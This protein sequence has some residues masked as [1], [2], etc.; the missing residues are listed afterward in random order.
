[1]NP[2]I[3]QFGPLALHWYG[4]F[5]VGGA[6]LATWLSARRAT[7]VGEDPDHVWNLLLWALG[8]GIIGARLYHVFSSPA[9]GGG[10]D[11]YRA[12]PL[13]ILMIWNGG[14]GIYGGLLGGILGIWIYTRRHGLSLLAYLDLIA[15]NVLLA[16][17][18][19]RLGNF[20]NQELYGPPTDLPWAF[21]INPI[22]PCQRPPNLPLNIQPCASPNLSAESL[23]WYAANGFHPTFFYEA[24]W[25]LLMFGLLTW[26]VYHFGSRLRRGD[27]TL[28]YFIAYPLGRFWVEFLR[29]DA[30]TLGSLATAQWIA[31]ISVVSAT[32]L[33]L[34]RRRRGEER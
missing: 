31:L 12:N 27:A 20:V 24:L 29:P 1:M 3:F 32:S 22:F 7:Q 19:G 10:W 25:N 5:I 33:L 23:A 13:A 14:L 8:F 30:W 17:A 26:A 6:A 15:P 11:Y 2:I 4:L 34:W 16:Q 9:D 28:L 18:I 21:T